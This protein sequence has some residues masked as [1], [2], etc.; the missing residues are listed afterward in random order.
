MKEPMDKRGIDGS[1]WIWE[2]P[3][4]SRQ[5]AVIADVARGD[6]KDFSTF[7]IVDVAEAKQVGEFKQQVSTRDFGNLLVAIAT[8][9]NDALLVIENANVGWAV[10]QQVIERGYKI[11]IILPKWI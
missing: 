3:D 11:Y 2:I 4:Y 10:I 7:H 8:E 9:Y 6:G 5:Y 1:L